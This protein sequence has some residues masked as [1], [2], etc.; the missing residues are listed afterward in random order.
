MSAARTQLAMA[1]TMMFGVGEE[2]F[3]N[4]ALGHDLFR[5]EPEA[6]KVW[7]ATA[8]YNRF[9]ANNQE[10]YQNARSLASLAIV[11]DNRSDGLKL[12]NGLSSRGVLYDVL[13]EDDITAER[14]KRYSCLVLLTENFRSQQV[15]NTLN[16]YLMTAG[17]KIVAVRGVAKKGSGENEGA[18]FQPKTES[19]QYLR[20]DTMPPIDELAQTLLSLN[21]TPAIEVT[22]PK[23][24]LYNVVEQR[25]AGRI[26][27]HLLNYTPQTVP[28]IRLVAHGDF[29]DVSLLSP[30]KLRSPIKRLSSSSSATE[31]EVRSL[32]IYSLIVFHQKRKN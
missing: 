23:G 7:D 5:A 10:Y 26:I 19:R 25:G 20:F 27:V 14:L 6:T 17:G 4:G 15:S 16:Q 29:D 21:R 3:V 12:M 22:A 30:D 11:L 18:I 32:D 31:V 24:V 13:Y 1:E 2:V 9:F 8:Q 28:D